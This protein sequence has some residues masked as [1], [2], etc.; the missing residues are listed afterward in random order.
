MH[1]IAGIGTFFPL[2]YTLSTQAKQA[3]SSQQQ[4]QQQQQ[5]QE[6]GEG[7]RGM[8]H[9]VENAMHP[10]HDLWLHVCVHAHV[11]SSKQHLRPLKKCWWL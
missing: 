5:L 4:R 2:Y 6:P 7:V 1:A 11:C 10:H 9:I 3:Y 8:R